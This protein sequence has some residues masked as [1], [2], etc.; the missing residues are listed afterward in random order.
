MI[1]MIYKPFWN[2]IDYLVKTNYELNDEHIELQY[3]ME[4]VLKIAWISRHVRITIRKIS[5]YIAM[6]EIQN[7]E[8]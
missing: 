1:L 8:Q 7:W 5:W 3:V 4:I 6:T 2:V